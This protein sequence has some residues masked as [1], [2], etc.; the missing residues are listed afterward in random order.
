MTSSAAEVWSDNFDDND[1]NDWIVTEGNFSI[2]NG[3]LRSDSARSTIVHNSSISTGTWSFDVYVESDNVTNTLDCAIYFINDDFAET[4]GLMFS[5]D[6]LLLIAGDSTIEQYQTTIEFTGWWNIKVTR[7]A[8]GLFTVFIN[9]FFYMS[10]VDLQF[11]SSSTFSFWSR[12]GSM[13]DNVVV[14][15]S[16]DIIQQWYDFGPLSL[17]HYVILGCALLFFI[18]SVFVI[19]KPSRALKYE[20]VRPWFYLG[21]F[22]IFG[23]AYLLP[24]MYFGNKPGIL[25]GLTQIAFGLIVPIVHRRERTKSLEASSDKSSSV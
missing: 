25:A 18:A 6:L 22:S 20:V 14:S 10:E 5:E 4:Y 8:S 13:L 2:V 9:D 21:V 3:A 23:V 19:V 12:T 1:Y 16:V 7:D 11:S 17:L 15:D 24:M